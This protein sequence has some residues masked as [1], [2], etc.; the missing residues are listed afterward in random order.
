MMKKLFAT[1]L[2]TGFC[3]LGASAQQVAVK[4]NL[5]YWAATT[6]NIGIDI[7]VGKHSTIGM[8]ANYN[9]W[10]LGT[11]NKIQHWFLRPEYRYWVTE[12][13]TRLYFGVHAI[14][15]EFEV[16]WLGASAQQVAVKTN[17]LYWAAT[18][19]NIGIDI[20]VGKHSTIGMT[21]NYNPWTLGTDNKIQHWFL[22]PEYRYWV[23]EKYTRL[24]FGV[25]AIGGEFEVGGFK[26]PFIGN[27]ILTG[28]PTHY[29]KGSFVGA[30]ISIGYQ[31]YV[32]P[33][34]NIEL[35]AGAGLARLSYHAEPVNGP[36]AAS[37]T[38]RK[39]I[40][41]IPTELGVSFVYLFNSKK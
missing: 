6:P 17:L 32:S 41:P 2:L 35:S 19:P 34:W 40:L 33:H 9:P 1:M 36:K 27:R 12:K 26:L 22:R 29:Y 7:A 4:T 20:A 3:W 5:L 39:R 23:T 25:H 8:T 31:F 15:G 37:Y 14:G 24:Y 10:T 11:D 13:Y 21:A 16:G 38:N 18:T 30:G 28:L